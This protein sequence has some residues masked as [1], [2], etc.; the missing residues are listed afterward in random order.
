MTVS[1]DQFKNYDGHAQRERPSE[2][3]ELILIWKKLDAI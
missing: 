3:P 1:V 2:D